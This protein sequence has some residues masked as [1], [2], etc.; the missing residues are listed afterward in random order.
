MKFF[1]ILLS[2]IA[3]SLK[4]KSQAKTYTCNL[5]FEIN[6]TSSQ[7]NFDRIDSVINTLGSGKI[8]VSIL[9]YA[10]FLY[11]ANYNKKLSGKR[12]EGVKNYLLRKTNSKQITIIECKGRGE[13]DSKDNQ[14]A[15]GE[16]SQRRVDV[17]VSEQIERKKISDKPN[18]IQ[19]KKE[20][21]IKPQTT[22]IKQ[23]NG[24][25]KNIQD[26]QKGETLTIEGL[27]FIPGRHIL[28]KAAIPVL[29][30]LLSTLKEHSDL[31]VEIQGHICCLDEA[32]EDGLDY[33]T[34]E[35]KLSENRAKA[36]YN[37]LIRNGI[38]ESRLTYKGYGHTQPKIK[39][40]K[41]PEEEQINRR[42]EIK[43][44]EN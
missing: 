20:K 37:Y 15:E 8:E 27:N 4:L 25:K 38:D 9:G 14:S 32:E 28:V 36:I 31:K 5:Y 35:K 21:V 2:I 22:Q 19:Q 6:K 39:Y 12:A 30:N 3:S 33:D 41:T 18:Q 10:D 13:E 44:L 34:E 1:F 17:M 29:E 16:P 24:E 40:E 7:S 11:D 42:V 26:L 43:V 23:I